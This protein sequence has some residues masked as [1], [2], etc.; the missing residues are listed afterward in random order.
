M[1]SPGKGDSLCPIIL[2]TRSKGPLLP[3]MKSQSTLNRS[4]RFKSFFLEQ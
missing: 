3:S 4:S 1:P 2:G